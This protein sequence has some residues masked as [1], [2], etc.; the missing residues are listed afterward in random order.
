M[1]LPDNN[2]GCWPPKDLAPVTRKLTTWSAWY[3]G[4][5]EQLANVYGGQTMGSDPTGTGFFASDQGGWRAGVRATLQRWF[6]G[7]RITPTEPRSKLHAPMAGDISAASA[8]LLFS[9]PP[10]LTATNTAAQDRLDEL[11]D[12]GV[13]ATWLEAAEICSALGGV[14]LRHVWDREAQPDGPWLTAMHPDAAVPEW[15]WGRLSAVT[16]WQVLRDDG[17]TVWRHLERHEPGRI[18]HAVYQGDAD[19]LGRRIPLTEFP[20]TA[21]LADVITDGGDTILTG[22]TALTSVYVPNMRPNRIWRNLP[23]AAYLGRSDYSGSEP[24]MDA[25]DETWTS[26]MRDLRLGK[27]RIIVPE[28][29]LQR[30]GPGKGARFDA[31]QEVFATLNMMPQTGQAPTITE[32]QFE[33]RVQQHRDTAL[34]LVSTIARAAGYSAQTFGLQGD[35]GQ[36]TATEVDARNDRSLA[37]RAKKVRYWR[38]ALAEAIETLMMLDAVVFSSG[39]TPERPSVEF[40]KGTPDNPETVARTLQL[41]AAAEAA[42]TETK[43]RMLHPDWDDGEVGEEVQKIRDDVS[44]GQP[45]PM[46]TLGGLAGNQPPADGGAGDGASNG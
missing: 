18:M 16:Y 26:W 1:P 45:P 5:P 29:Y 22:I 14:Y 9:E 40:P 35:G 27:A 11:V 30:Q 46:D 23:A 31:E 39:V 33:I 34:E 42:S 3:S 17:R 21:A 8:D 12:D 7:T 20:E 2:S 37:T 10:K 4:D 43:V 44:A 38:P 32:N 25:L 24:L 28:A 15:R 41:L 6:W 13:H 19:E 36:Q